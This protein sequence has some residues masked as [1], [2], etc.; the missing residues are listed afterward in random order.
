[1]LLLILLI[2]SLAPAG[3]TKEDDKYGFFGS[4]LLGAGVA[5]SKPSGLT[6]TDDNKKIDT[7]H[8]RTDRQNRVIPLILGEFGYS[9]AATG[10]RISLS[11]QKSEKSF[12]D[13]VVEQPLKNLGTLRASFGYGKQDVWAN[14]YLTGVKRSETEE[15]S[16]NMKLEW[17]QI[18]GSGFFATL[19]LSS[20]DVDQDL[21]GEMYQDLKRDGQIMAAKTGY[22]FF[23]GKN[24]MIIPGFDIEVEDR[25]GESNASKKFGASVSH[26]IDIHKWHF[27]TSLGMGRREFDKA[28]PIFHETRKETQYELSHLVTYSSPFGFK[29]WFVN[30]LAAYSRTDANINFFKQDELTIGAGIGYEF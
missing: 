30:G 19:K 3:Q 4:I 26:V 22:T 25:D 2:P 7:L 13:V 23:V 24:Q 20:I 28:H 27:I 29:G 10:T 21:I 9:F 18:A 1:M 11:N 17:E 15:A 8:D 12:A 5:A 16:Y 6:V 14:P